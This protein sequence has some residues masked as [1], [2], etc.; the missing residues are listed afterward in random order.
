M[1]IIPG[2]DVSGVEHK[3]TTQLRNR[4]FQQHQSSTSYYKQLTHYRILKFVDNALVGYLGLDYRVMNLNGN[5][6]KVYY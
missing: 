1:K 6:G 2:L 4:V 3:V 5:P